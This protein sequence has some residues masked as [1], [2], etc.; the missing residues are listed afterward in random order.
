MSVRVIRMSYGILSLL[1]MLA[2]VPAF[3]PSAPL[4]TFDPNSISTSIVETANAAATQTALIVSSTPPATDTPLP[5]FTPSSTPSPTVTF[6]FVLF[7]PTVA[8]ST[9]APGSSGLKFDCIV[10]AKSPSDGA[11]VNPNTNFNMVWK[12]TN[13][14]TNSWDENSADYRFR[15]GDK[16]HKAGTYDF[17]SSVP[18]GGQTDIKVEMKAPGAGGSY[19]TSWVIRV[20]QVEF[21]R[22][23][24][25]INV[26]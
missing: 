12:V 13:M 11:T 26:P 14:G 24:I 1:V 23:S 9:P 19:S 16:L 22:M 10:N 18:P 3:R 8:T 21:C 25:T 5:T 20:G 2:C 17:N 15:S 7:T 6:I 4:P